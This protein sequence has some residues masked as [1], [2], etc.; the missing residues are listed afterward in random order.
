MSDHDEAFSPGN[1]I[2]LRMRIEYYVPRGTSKALRTLF[3]GDHI[4]FKKFHIMSFVIQ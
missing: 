4:S 2:L 3:L 1:S